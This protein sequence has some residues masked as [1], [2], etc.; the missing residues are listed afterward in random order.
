MQT[1]DKINIAFGFKGIEIVQSVLNPIPILTIKPE[2]FIFNIQID[3]KIDAANKL[4]HVFVHIHVLLPEI[5]EELGSLSTLCVFHVENLDE[6]LKNEGDNIQLPDHFMN[7][8]SAIAISTSRGIMFTFFKG[9][10]LHRA[11]LPIIDPTKFKPQSLIPQ[12][13]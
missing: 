11:I 7:T 5:K 8:L 12:P 1:A 4:I 9:T 6:V 3:Q 2:D 10:Y 13:V